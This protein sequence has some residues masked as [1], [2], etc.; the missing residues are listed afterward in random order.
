MAMV[1]GP[2][3]GEAIKDPTSRINKFALS[4]KDDGKVVDEIYL[5]VLNRLPT[6]KERADHRTERPHSRPSTTANASAAAAIVATASR[7][8]PTSAASG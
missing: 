4:E 5:S 7:R 8:M 1:N 6:A 2:I 3:V